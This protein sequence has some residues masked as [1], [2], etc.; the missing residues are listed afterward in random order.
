MRIA[1]LHISIARTNF[2]SK[3]SQSTQ[4]RPHQGK[5]NTP[6]SVS[7]ERNS[8]PVFNLSRLPVRHIAFWCG[9]GFLFRQNSA[10]ECMADELGLR[11]ETELAHEACQMNLSCAQADGKK[12]ATFS[13]RFPK[14]HNDVSF[15]EHERQVEQRN[16]DRFRK[17]AP[18]KKSIYSLASLR[19]ILA[20]CHHRYLDFTSSIDDPETGFR[21]RN[22]LHSSLPGFLRGIQDYALSQVLPFC[23][24]CRPVRY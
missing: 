10:A 9:R 23:A 22:L 4:N 6:N 11:V 13:K 20:A 17:P 12:D 7:F 21:C 18:S 14:Y 15:F 19:E 24:Q 3:E 1:I 2:I 5:T 8:A 16:G